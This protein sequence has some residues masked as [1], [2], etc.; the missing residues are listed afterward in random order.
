MVAPIHPASASPRK[1]R[2]KTP[3]ESNGSS[4]SFCAIPTW[5]GLMGLNA[6]PT[7]AAPALIATAVSA[8]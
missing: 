8:S 1:T 3:P 5:N 7:A 4:A 6:A 2:R